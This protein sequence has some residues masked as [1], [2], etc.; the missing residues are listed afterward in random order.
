[1]DKSEQLL[2][3]LSQIE[4]DQDNLLRELLVKANQNT[5]LTAKD[6]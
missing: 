4:D 1:M 3:V 5:R 6:L 2:S